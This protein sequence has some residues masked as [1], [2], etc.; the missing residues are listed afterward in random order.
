MLSC[1]RIKVRARYASWLNIGYATAA[2]PRSVMNSRRCMSAPK[3]R[4]RHPIGLIEY[5][6]TDENWHREL[7]RSAQLMSQ[8]GQKAMRILLI[9][10]G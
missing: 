8:L 2:P 7:C 4:R 10:G 6:D 5:F 1:F 9:L 3:L